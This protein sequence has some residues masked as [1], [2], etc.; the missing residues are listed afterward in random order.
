MIKLWWRNTLHYFLG[1][2][3]ENMGTAWMNSETLINILIL[4]LPDLGRATGCNFSS[5][6]KKPD[7]NLVP[8][9]E[10]RKQFEHDTGTESLRGFPL[11][12]GVNPE[13][14]TPK[15][16]H[17]PLMCVSA[18]PAAGW[19]HR[20]ELGSF[21]REGGMEMERQVL[22][23]LSAVSPQRSARVSPGASLQGRGWCI[24]PS[25]LGMQGCFPG[26]SADQLQLPIAHLS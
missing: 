5:E 16:E 15:E 23:L 1:P 4:N 17:S 25:I 21:W 12:P 14:R 9:F 20:W 10:H 13:S 3:V 7:K 8:N 22:D 19:E 18:V 6:S 24:A 11:M 2:P 26:K